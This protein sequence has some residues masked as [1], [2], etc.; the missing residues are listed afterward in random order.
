MVPEHLYED[1]IA[2]GF[3]V[4]HMPRGAEPAATQT[5][6]PANPQ[7]QP[8]TKPAMPGDGRSGAAFDLPP[9]RKVFPAPVKAAPK[10]RKAEG[11]GKRQK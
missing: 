9:L 2:H 11:N 5:D 3:L 6:P 4:S 1:A 7:R 8:L 10:P